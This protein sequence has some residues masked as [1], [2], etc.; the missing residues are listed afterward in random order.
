MTKERVFVK[1][2]E[3]EAGMPMTYPYG[4]SSGNIQNFQGIILAGNHSGK[5]L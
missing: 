5:I 1:Q 4:M 2:K 3:G